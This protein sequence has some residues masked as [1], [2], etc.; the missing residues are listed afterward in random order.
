MYRLINQLV[1]VTDSI[2]NMMNT[3]QTLCKI[4]KFSYLSN[5]IKK[6]L[7]ELALMKKTCLL[8]KLC[9]CQ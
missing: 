2:R 4:D 3:K 9:G 5:T 8:S 1:M 6:D 7:I